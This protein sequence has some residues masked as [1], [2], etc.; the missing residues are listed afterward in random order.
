MDGASTPARAPARFPTANVAL[1][2]ATI[3]T[4]L[5]AGF[6]FSP[7][8][9][10]G[11]TFARVLEGGLPFAAA[12]VAILFTHE[13]GHYVVARRH[14]VSTTLPYFIPFPF[15]AGT[16]GAVIK[17]RS[18]L[19]SRR[20]TLEIGAAGPIAGFVVA[21]PILLWGLAHSEAR[22]TA[23]LAEVG[24]GTSPFGLLR[25][26]LTGQELLGGGMSGV[27]V[28]GDSL[29]TWAAQRLVFGPAPAGADLMID[30]HPAV[31]AAWVGLFVTTLNL[32]PVGQLDGGH[33]LYALLGRDG[34]RRVGRLVSWGLLLAGFFLSFNW[35]VWWALTRWL[36]GRG[37]PP[38]LVEEPLSPLHRA[39]AIGSLV[40]FVATFVPVP[41]S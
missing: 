26:W 35:L 24:A 38:A 16:L 29:V 33:V 5:W 41:I 4:T 20:A 22:A 18:P 1:F 9:V 39:L 25:A 15:G 8:A 13:M 40:L 37:H 23:A 28:Y 6:W 7:L 10:E 21:L 30:P 31:L 12:L 2:V 17:I 14:G 32:V 19:P 34:A 3:A 36:V 11:P 27:L